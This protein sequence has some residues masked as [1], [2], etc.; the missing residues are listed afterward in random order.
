[1][2]GDHL[3]QLTTVTSQPCHPPGN[4]A[5][6]LPVFAGRFLDFSA[7]LGRTE[8]TEPLTSVDEHGSRAD[9]STLLR[10]VCDGRRRWQLLMERLLKK[11]DGGMRGRCHLQPDSLRT[12][13]HNIYTTCT[14]SVSAQNNLKYV[15]LEKCKSFS[16]DVWGRGHGGGGRGCDAFTST[17]L[18]CV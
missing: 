1:M 10:H 15:S 11:S 5:S 17:C 9:E 12:V 13:I 14:S 18:A 2:T 6:L 4:S 8:L 3:G 7:A 16:R